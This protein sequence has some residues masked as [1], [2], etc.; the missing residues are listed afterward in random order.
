[1][2]PSSQLPREG[3]ILKPTSWLTKLPVQGAPYRR[4]S[5]LQQAASQPRSHRPT[6]PVP[7]RGDSSSGRESP[8]QGHLASH[9]HLQPVSAFLTQCCLHSNCSQLLTPGVNAGQGRLGG[10]ISWTQNQSEWLPEPQ[11]LDPSNGSDWALWNCIF[12]RQ[13]HNL[14]LFCQPSSPAQDRV[15][16]PSVLPWGVIISQETPPTPGSPQGDC[17]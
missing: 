12:K 6:V 16:R 5:L 15:T 2:L 7:R 14:L 11:F 13:S 17:A 4:C 1:M 10:A 8:R 3:G 9:N